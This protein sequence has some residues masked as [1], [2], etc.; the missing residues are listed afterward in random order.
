MAV[1][2]SKYK[3]FYLSGSMVTIFTIFALLAGYIEYY[4]GYE[5]VVECTSE[6]WATFCMKNGNHNL[7]FYNKE[8]VPLTF[9]PVSKV[10]KVEF[11][12]KDGRFKSGYRPINFIDPYSK[13]VNYVFKIP[14]YSY[15]CYGMK[16]YK[17]PQST[18]K[19]TFAGLDPFLQAP[20]GNLTISIN[21]FLNQTHIAQNFQPN[22]SKAFAQVNFSDNTTLQTGN[23]EWNFSEYNISANVTDYVYN[24]SNNGSTNYSVWGKINGPY[25]QNLV[26]VWVWWNGVRK[27]N[28][29]NASFTELFPLNTTDWTELVNIT[30]D[31]IN[32]SQTYQNW[33]LVANNTNFDFNLTFNAT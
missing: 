26:K 4:D 10:H 17:D 20:D 21:S 8:E 25:N 27:I 33:S 30:I 19:W 7:Y 12:K 9:S 29:S 31:L 1:K 23:F 32:L 2:G 3:R 6:C 13:G 11:Y 16:V 15:T 18:V 14:R 5:D 24:F 22:L 28:L